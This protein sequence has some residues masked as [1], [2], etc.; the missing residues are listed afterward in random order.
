MPEGRENF[1]QTFAE[2]RMD[3]QV[4]RLQRNTQTKDIEHLALELDI[5]RVVDGG[6]LRDGVQRIKV[7][8]GGSEQRVISP[9]LVTEHKTVFLITI[10]GALI[11]LEFDVS[12]VDTTLW[13]CCKTP[14]DNYK[15]NL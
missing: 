10:N 14:K 3:Q 15:R 1:N 6:D 7:R 8:S 9:F 4:E 5:R 13:I 11:S 2:P 12:S